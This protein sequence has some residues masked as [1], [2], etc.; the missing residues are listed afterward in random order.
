MKLNEKIIFLRKQQGWSQEELAEHLDVS[1]QSV[2]KWES[3]ASTPELDRIVEICNLFG[4]SA[5]SLIREDLTLEAPSEEL[6]I[7]EETAPGRTRMTM[8]D[9]YAYIAQCQVISRKIAQGVGACVLSPSVVVMFSEV[10]FLCNVVGLPIMFLLIAWGVWQFITAGTMAKRYQFVEKGE[11]CTAPG[12]TQ[13]VRESRDQFQPM[14]MRDI[15]FGVVLCILSP[16]PMVIGEELYDWMWW[17]E[18]FAPALLL[19]MVAVGVYLFVRSGCLQ[20][21]YQKLLKEK[22]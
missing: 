1:R 9:A 16:I 14:L 6:E 8:D 2:S 12:V 3:G 17:S 21:G 7:P 15:A 20:A 10:D 11:F 5:D 18:G 4:L 13:W 22:H 19:A